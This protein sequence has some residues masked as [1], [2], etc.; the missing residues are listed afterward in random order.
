MA[1]SPS[2]PVDTKD[3]R[4]ASFKRYALCLWGVAQVVSTLANAIKRLL[5]IAL[6]PFQQNDLTA[7]QWGLYIAWCLYMT[8]AE[9]YK[10]FQQKF[11]PMVV[12]RAWGIL[13]N[14][15]IFNT[16]LAGPYAMGM[17]GADRKRMIVSWAIM[18]GVFSLV[19]I[20]K[21]LPYPYRSI[22]DGGVVCG[23]SYGAMSI[24]F[25]TIRR[26]FFHKEEEKKEEPT[27]QD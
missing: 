11:S 20:V 5:P 14:A 4:M 22:V 26:F 6:Q 25:L 15:N 7:P 2:K 27:K 13:D 1:Q 19:K 9:G 23:L 21:F 17:F 12:E 24:V 8:Y 16:V 3:S 18:A 10:A